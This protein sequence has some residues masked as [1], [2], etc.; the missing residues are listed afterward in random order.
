MTFNIGLYGQVVMTIGSVD[1]VVVG[2]GNDLRPIEPTRLGYYPGMCTALN[3]PCNKPE[4]APKTKCGEML[5]CT[6]VT[7]QCF[8]GGSW[9][10]S[11]P[12]PGGKQCVD[13]VRNRLWKYEQIFPEAHYMVKDYCPRGIKEQMKFVECFC[14]LTGKND[15]PWHP[16]PSTTTTTPPPSPAPAC[17]HPYPGPHPDDPTPDAQTCGLSPKCVAGLKSFTPK[18]KPI[19]K[20]GGKRCYEG[21]RLWGPTLTEKYGCPAFVLRDG[22]V[23]NGMLGHAW[24]WC[25][26][27]EDILDDTSLST[28][29]HEDAFAPIF[30]RGNLSQL[31]LQF[32]A[33]FGSSKPPEDSD[34]EKPDKYK[35]YPHGVGCCRDQHDY[36][37]LKRV[38]GSKSLSQITADCVAEVAEH[39]GCRNDDS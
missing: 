29:V 20:N 8:S 36:F 7:A 4:P 12:T 11:E 15:N 1:T 30:G 9:N 14:G 33:K 21:L 22:T 16:W 5:Q 25:G 32:D 28:S 13:C 38:G 35:Q 2:F 27:D 26:L 24:C 10:H 39:K 34:C 31:S 19:K 17:P 18:C 37:Q 3:L 6:G 23:P